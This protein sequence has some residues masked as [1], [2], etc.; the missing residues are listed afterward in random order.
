MTASPLTIGEAMMVSAAE[1][2]AACSTMPSFDD[3]RVA[4]SE[5]R[6]GIRADW[7]RH[8]AGSSLPQ[9]VVADTRNWM[10]HALESAEWDVARDFSFDRAMDRQLEGALA[11]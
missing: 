3:F 1:F 4:D 6:R 10:A 9:R 8:L 11:P 7:E 2:D 5:R